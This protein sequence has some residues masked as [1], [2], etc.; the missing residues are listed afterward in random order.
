M[1][2]PSSGA[3]KRS[4]TAAASASADCSSPRWDQSLKVGNASAAFSP[5]P[6]KLKPVTRKDEA[7]ASRGCRKPSSSRT[8]ASVRARV[9]PGGSWMSTMV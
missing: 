1:M 8:A 7:T 3:A 9:A 4:F 5:M 6:E 2:A